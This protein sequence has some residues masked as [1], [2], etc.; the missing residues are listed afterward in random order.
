MRFKIPLKERT[1]GCVAK[2]PSEQ[3]GVCLVLDF[4]KT[5]EVFPQIIKQVSDKTLLV[6]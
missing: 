4:G 3:C 1:R 2:N 6:P 5:C